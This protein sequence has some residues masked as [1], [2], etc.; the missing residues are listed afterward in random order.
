MDPI[1]TI[2]RSS[3]GGMALAFGGLDFVRRDKLVLSVLTMDF[4][5][6]ALGSLRALMPVSSRD[7][8]AMG[9]GGLGLLYAAP[10]AGALTGTLILG[11]L[12]GGWRRP[13][14]ILVS[15]ALFG[16]CTLGFGL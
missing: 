13:S 8:L 3:R 10:A 6:T 5:V 1:T 11:A 9:A 4:L 7:I 14:V 2:R 15:S 12:A 16:L